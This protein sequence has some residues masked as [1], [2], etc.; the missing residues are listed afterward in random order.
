[1]EIIREAEGDR[2]RGKTILT[3]KPIRE[4]YQQDNETYNALYEMYDS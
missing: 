2:G 4:E 3:V 1:M